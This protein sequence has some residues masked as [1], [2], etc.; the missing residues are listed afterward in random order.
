[1]RCDGAKRPGKDYLSWIM[2]ARYQKAIFFI[3]LLTKRH[4]YI[5]PIK[6]LKL[7]LNTSV[8][9]FRFVLWLLPRQC[10]K[11]KRFCNFFAFEADQNKDKSKEQTHN[12]D[13]TF[14]PRYSYDWKKNNN[15]MLNKTK[16]RG[17]YG[18]IA[19][20]AFPHTEQ[21]L[22]RHAG[23]YRIIFFFKF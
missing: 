7:T 2:H 13:R 3:A 4:T 11:S 10:L 14:N 5:W 19:T 8:V 22:H 21:Y 1:M 9:G 17:F 20:L 18:F 12:T 15:C 23:L 16:I 6:L